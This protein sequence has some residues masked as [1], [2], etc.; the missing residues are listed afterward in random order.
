MMKPEH[1]EQALAE[2]ERLLGIA[3]TVATTPMREIHALHR[4]IFD[5]YNPM[6]VLDVVAHAQSIDKMNEADMI[7][8]AASLVANAMRVPGA[9][10]ALVRS[11][12]LWLA[13]AFLLEA[14]A[15]PQQAH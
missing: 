14:D 2:Q 4:V 7:V 8:V 6:R 10:P 11:T 9:N 3:E 1:G 12:I 13:Q 15:T 5:S